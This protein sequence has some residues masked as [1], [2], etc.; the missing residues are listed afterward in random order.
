MATIR[1]V[2]AQNLDD[3]R[4]WLLMLLA[5]FSGEDWSF[6]PGPGLAHATWLCGHLA[7]SQDTLVHVRVLGKGVLGADFKA[8]FPIGV[9]V[10]SM[11]EHRYPPVAEI[12]AVMDDVHR[13]TLA[14]V[15]GIDEALLAQPAFAADGKSP[16]P[17]YRDKLGVIQHA[18]R[19]EAFHAGQLALLRRLRG[20]KFLR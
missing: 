2:L 19:H 20:K 18:A 3:T 9:E 10:P 14:A 4:Q 15:R 13:Q 5:D 1:D 8:H 6:V 7:A 12:R 16:H 17:H 11:T